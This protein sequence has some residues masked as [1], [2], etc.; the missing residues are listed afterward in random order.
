MVLMSTST[1]FHG[2]NI[3]VLLWSDLFSKAIPMPEIELKATVMVRSCVSPR[4]LFVWFCKARQ[5]LMATLMNMLHSNITKFIYVVLEDSP[6]FFFHVLGKQPPNFAPDF[7]DLTYGMTS[8]YSPP[9]L[10]TTQS[11][12]HIRVS[13]LPS[14][15]WQTHSFSDHHAWVKEMHKKNNISISHTTHAG[16][17]FTVET[18]QNHRA[19]ML[20]T[21][22]MGW[23][24]SGA[25]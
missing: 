11:Q 21:K 14:M 6:S 22:A 20:S 18:T 8:I 16:C 15:T 1:T 2:D 7:T 25:Y 23:K 5:I 19:S 3:Q 10:V 17:T 9:L 12:W 13:V 4:C 24:D